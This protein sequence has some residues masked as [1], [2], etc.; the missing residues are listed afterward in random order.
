MI[1]R[2]SMPAKG[3]SKRMKVGFVAR[4]PG[5]FCSFFLHREFEPISFGKFFQIKLFQQ[6]MQSLS[7]SSLRDL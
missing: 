7:I 6:N 5:Y 1:A 2:G 4:S 3:S